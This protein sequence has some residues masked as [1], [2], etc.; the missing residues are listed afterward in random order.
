MANGFKK[1]VGAKWFQRTSAVA[2]GLVLLAVVVSIVLAFVAP[3]DKTPTAQDPTTTAPTQKAPS[4]SGVSDSPTAD[5]KCNVPAG[6]MSFEPKM[7]AD[8]K[9]E[10]SK[11]FTWPAS[12]SIG[13]TKSQG[14]A[15][16]CYARSPL[17][18]ALFVTNVY[19]RINTADTAEESVDV[20][21]AYASSAAQKS[22]LSAQRSEAS[23]ASPE[24]L[25]VA[26]N[27]LLSAGASNVG[28]VVDRFDGEQATVAVV[29]RVAQ[30]N[31][32]YV[33]AMTLNLVW[34]QGD[35][36]I[37]DTTTSSA[38]VVTADGFVPWRQ[39]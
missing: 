31:T 1:M 6:D 10:A 26:R 2:L 15:G 5:G 14:P 12:A 20:L 30:T 17:G 21:I 22:N 19:N 9:W 11:G 8:L 18:A 37:S 38:G 25:E 16:S 3:A 13:P 7:P 28:F 33:R 34:S 35:W 36:K 23:K 24:D 29:L 39:K 4:A 27:Q 32:G